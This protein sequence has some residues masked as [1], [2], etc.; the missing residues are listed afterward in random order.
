M[1]YQNSTNIEND[2]TMT[3]F[4]L[5]CNVFSPKTNMFP[6]LPITQM[7]VCML[8]SLGEETPTWPFIV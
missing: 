5:Y 7:G 4:C 2:Q 3:I 1:I 6:S 8:P